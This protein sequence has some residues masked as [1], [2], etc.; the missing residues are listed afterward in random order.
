MAAAEA[1]NS[2]FTADVKKEV[3]EIEARVRQRRG[4]TSY[5]KDEEMFQ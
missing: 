2:R 1:Y 3:E 4:M 5:D